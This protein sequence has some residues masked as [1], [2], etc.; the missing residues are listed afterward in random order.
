AKINGTSASSST[1]GEEKRKR[2]YVDKIPTDWSLDTFKAR[3]QEFG[4]VTDV[5]IFERPGKKFGFV[6]FETSTEAINAI[7]AYGDSASRNPS[8][9]VSF[10]IDKQSQANQQ[11]QNRK[12][13][14]AKELIKLAAEDLLS[15]EK[16]QRRRK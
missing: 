11:R 15:P 4:K 6:E 13:H 3:F 2:L 8:L 9:S 5:R 1:S 7:K 12:R 10:S 16:K 14:L